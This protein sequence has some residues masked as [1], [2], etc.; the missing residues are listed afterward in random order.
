MERLQPGMLVDDVVLPVERGKIRELVRA[1][2][3]VDPVHVDRAAAEA[4]GLPDVAAP[5]TFS[6]TTAHLRDQAAFTAA[7]GLDAGRVVVGSV[8]WEY[9]RPIAA[10]EELRVVRRVEGDT[11]RTGRS[12]PMRLVVLVTEF[13]DAAGERVLVQRETLIE[14]GGAA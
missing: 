4:A 6:A 10:G 14:R 8:S 13:T 12:G 9:V 7:L 11:S 2:G 1:T 5:L 3:T